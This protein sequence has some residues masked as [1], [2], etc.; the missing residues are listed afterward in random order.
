MDVGAHHPVKKEGGGGRWVQG[1]SGVLLVM[2]LQRAHSRG[3]YRG[4][5]LK[6]GFTFWT[7]LYFF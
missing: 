6:G 2:H 1:F 7:W 5:N 4:D 3:S